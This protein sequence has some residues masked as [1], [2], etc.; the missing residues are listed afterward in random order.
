METL[1]AS[2]CRHSQPVLE[3][4]ENYSHRFR[5][6][7]TKCSLGNLCHVFKQSL[8]FLD[9]TYVVIDAIDECSERQDLVDQLKR[10]VDGQLPLNLF[11]TSREV[12]DIIVPLES[13]L[14]KQCS[15]M[16]NN[17]SEDISTY[18]SNR[19]DDHI[20]KKELRLRDPKLRNE[21]QDTL[22]SKANGM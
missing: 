1:I 5:Q 16:P 15:L 19:L 21:I 22:C 12:R 6:T 14:I 11:L 2:L 7:R 8:A 3:F 4:V 20:R 13:S 17:L 10:L 18:I 9:K